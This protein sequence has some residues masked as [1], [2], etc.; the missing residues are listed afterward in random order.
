MEPQSMKDAMAADGYWIA[1]GLL[2]PDEVALLRHGLTAH[3]TEGW[4]WEGL[5]KHQPFASSLIPSIGWIFTH[6]RILDVFRSLTDSPRPV[7]PGNCDAHLNMLSWWHKDT[8]EG[9]GGCFEGDYFARP[10]LRV[11][12]A[13]IYMQDHIDNAQGLHVRPGSH[14]TRSPLTGQAISLPTRAGDVIFFDIRLSHAGQL[15][16]PIEAMLL[17][18]TRWLRAPAAGFHAKET[19]RLLTRRAD[20]LSIFFTYGAP[21]PDAE[22]Y[23]RFEF[24]ARQRA[25]I[26]AALSLPPALQSKLA[27]SH[28]TCNPLLLPQPVE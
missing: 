17:R 6:P 22:R 1:R 11:F 10:E 16:D 9:Q 14:M 21:T 5:G 3:F 18:A 19:W 12:R 7:F 13:G 27:A 23:C 25:G 24:A 15:A 8:S 4:N 28:V 20:K 26:L 2:D